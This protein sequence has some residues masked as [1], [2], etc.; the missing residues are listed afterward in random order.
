M[1]KDVDGRLKKDESSEHKSSG[2]LPEKVTHFSDA[3]DKIVWTKFG[4]VL[5]E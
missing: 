5:K 2:V 3:A 4:G 1:I